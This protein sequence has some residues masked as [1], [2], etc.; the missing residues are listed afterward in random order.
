MSNLPPTDERVEIGQ[1][2]RDPY[3]L[4]ARYRRESP[5]VYA[6]SIKRTLLTKA[7]DI[8]AVKN[9]SE[10]F[11]SDDPTTPMKRAFQAHTLMRKDGEA[12]RAERMAM[13]PAFSPTCIREHWLPVYRSISKR[14]VEALPRGEVVDLFQ[15]LAAPW[16]ANC[17]THL[18]GLE[19]SDDDMCRWSQVLID[20]AGN[21]GYRD[22]LFVASDAANVEMDAHF[23]SLQA[24]HQ[25][26]RG[27]SAF[28]AMLNA[29]DPIPMSQIYSNI[30]IAIG[31][32]INE[33][34]DA[35]CTILYGLLNQPEYWQDIKS[36]PSLCG[37]AFDEG[38]RWVAPI[39]ASSRI[40]TRDTE[41]HGYSILKGTVLMTVQA[42]ANHDEDL[43][44]KGYV[45]DLHRGPIKHQAF[46][47]GPHFCQ[48]NR[49]ARAMIADIM[50]PLLI[51][52]FP[53]LELVDPESVTFS[54]FG[55]RGPLS[56]P[57]KLH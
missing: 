20:G 54:G 8:F 12:H 57:V 18:L 46:G 37:A 55:F 28:A 53:N 14:Y 36:D 16:A 32:G 11:S 33:P 44:D 9:D 49:V 30:K 38:V 17:L 26:E 27:P 15:V 24:A 39:Q 10:L 47:N 1:F 42:S 19:A 56:L 23:D 43:L 51:E 52:H 4:Y 25:S 6:K 34:R 21:F 31:G 41:I 48:G 3:S 7:E 40:A 5:V 50:L 2:I 45:F 29:A 22:E 35:L 13:A